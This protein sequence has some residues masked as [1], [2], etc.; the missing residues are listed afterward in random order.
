MR[1]YLI[2]VRLQHNLKN[3][4]HRFYINFNYAHTLECVY[5]M[6]LDRAWHI[7]GRVE[8]SH[9]EILFDYGNSDIAFNLIM[10]ACLLRQGG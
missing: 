4:T 9:E 5:G 10:L 2:Q 3:M 6:D 8:D 1:Q 7:H